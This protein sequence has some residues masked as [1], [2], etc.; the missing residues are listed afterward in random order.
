MDMHVRK[1]WKRLFSFY[2][3]YYISLP[4]MAMI[5]AHETARGQAISS[6]AL[7]SSLT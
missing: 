5:S 3:G 2:H 7:A 6:L 4:A 1:C